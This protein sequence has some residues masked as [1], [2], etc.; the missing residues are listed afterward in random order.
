MAAELN[1][2]PGSFSWKKKKRQRENFGGREKTR[3]GGSGKKSYEAAAAQHT[4]RARRSQLHST[5]RVSARD[6][7]H[8]WLLKST[9]R[10][11]SEQDEKK[12]VPLQP[13][14]EL[15]QQVIAPTLSQRETRKHVVDL[16]LQA[17]RRVRTDTWAAHQHVRGRVASLELI[18][19]LFGID[20]PM[21]ESAILA[22]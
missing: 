10:L 21:G 19:R 18:I 12:N 4:A 16:R 7:M 5:L 1:A 11:R 2:A 8:S 22:R 6:R 20:P 14:T 9:A 17:R 13:T 3:K 15:R